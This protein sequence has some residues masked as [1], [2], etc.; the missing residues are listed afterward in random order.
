MQPGRGSRGGGLTLGM[1]ERSS[2]SSVTR[3]EGGGQSPQATATS[4]NWSSQNLPWGKRTGTEQSKDRFGSAREEAQALVGRAEGG[5][6]RG[7]P[8]ALQA[9]GAVQPGAAACKL[10][11]LRG[12]ELPLMCRHQPASL[13]C[14]ALPKEVW[15]GP[16]PCLPPPLAHVLLYLEQ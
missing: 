14:P 15:A 12:G 11:R 2:A 1:W 6:R 3:A 8:A 9:M 16:A 5:I 4:M 10:Q 7:A 13:P